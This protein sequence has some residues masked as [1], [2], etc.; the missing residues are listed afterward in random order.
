MEKVSSK[1]LQFHSTIHVDK[2]LS[3]L[4]SKVRV[5]AQTIL[6]H[7]KNTRM[8][9]GLQIEFTRRCEKSIV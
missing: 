3:N 5:F 8:I 9:E 4:K 2:T 6:V 7:G 1:G